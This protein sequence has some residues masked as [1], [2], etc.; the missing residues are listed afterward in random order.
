[1]CRHP[2]AVD[3]LL[4]VAVTVRNARAV[5][6]RG[7]EAVATLRA[8]R[9]RVRQEVVAGHA[10]TVPAMFRRVRRMFR[11][12]I[13]VI[14]DPLLAGVFEV[15]RVDVAAQEIDLLAERKRRRR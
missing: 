11:P 15:G 14:P 8:R 3:P 10:D 4:L 1:M 9:V 5:D 6:A 12:P 13:V 2:F 7:G